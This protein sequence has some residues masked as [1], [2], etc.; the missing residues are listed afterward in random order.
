[1]GQGKVGILILIIISVIAVAGIGFYEVF[2]P[3]MN[4]G[5]YQDRVKQAAIQLEK[6]LRVIENTTT[7]SLIDDPSAALSIKQNDARITKAAMQD[8]Q[9]DITKLQ[10]ASGEL[11]QSPYTGFTIQ[12]RKAQALQERSKATI[13]QIQDALKEYTELVAF[14]EFYA[15]AQDR[16][17]KELDDFNSKTDLNVYAG[18]GGDIR[19]IATRIRQDAA[20]LEKQPIPRDL[21]NFRST[22]LATHLRAADAFDDLANGLTVVVDAIIYSAATEIESVTAQQD[23]IIQKTYEET[24]RQSRTVKDVQEI[25]EKLEPLKET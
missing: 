18:Q 9:A 14:L 25:V 8:I 24:L 1:M 19:A 2:F 21:I 22:L 20:V 11:K 4:A 13:K 3:E 6:K 23:T 17:K 10:D 12:Y 5:Q 15:G 16:L 7:L